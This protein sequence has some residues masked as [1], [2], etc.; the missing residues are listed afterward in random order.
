MLLGLGEVIAP[1]VQMLDAPAV[2]APRRAVADL[3]GVADAVSGARDVEQLSRPLL[4]A[5]HDLTGLASAYLTVIHEDEDVQE[6]RYSRSGRRRR[7]PRPT[8]TR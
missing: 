2:P 1:L 7:R 5:L 8:P 3:A 6:I 4:D